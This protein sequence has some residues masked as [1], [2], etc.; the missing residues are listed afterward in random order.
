L[1]E[2]DLLVALLRADRSAEIGSLLEQVFDQY[3]ARVSLVPVGGRD[4]NRGQIE[5]GTDPGKGI[6][7]RI[8]NGIDGVLELEEKRHNGIPECKSPREAAMSWLNVPSKGLH[9]LSAARRRE[10]A[11]SVVVTVTEGDDKSHRTVTIVDS[12]IGMAAEEMP[13]TILSLGESN[14]VQKLYLSGAFG[15]GGSSTFAYCGYSVICSRSHSN[16]KN[17]GFTIIYYQDLPAEKYKHGN[18]VYLTLD[19]KLFEAEVSLEHFPKGTMVKHLGYDVTEYKYG[20]GPQSVYG[21][22]QRALFDP[23]IPVSLEDRVSKINRV[24]KGS[25]NALNGAVDDPAE[26]GPSIRYNVPMYHVSLGDFGHIGLE[27]WLL[28]EGESEKYEP[29]RAYVDN[30]K[31]ILL[32]VNGQTHAEYSGVL[33]RSK[34]QADL[35]YLR[36]RLIIHV[37]CNNLTPSAKRN[38]FSSSREDVRKGQINNLIEQEIVKALKSDDQLHILN[39]EAKSLTL[40]K[41]DT[42]SEQTI[43][44]EVAKVLRFHGFSATIAAGGG[45]DEGS[46]NT[47]SRIPPIP[48]APTH[49]FTKKIDI[50]DPPT[51]VKILAES[52]TDFYP[53]QRRYIRVETDAPSSYHNAEDSTKSR[54]N[55][56]INRTEIVKAGTTPLREG[57]MR[58]ILDCKS[59]AGVGSTGEL[60]I[61]LTVPGMPTLTDK[62]SYMI[63]KKPPP[64]AD[65]KHISIPKIR[66]VKVEGPEDEVWARLTW[67]DE[68]TKVASSSELGDELVVY[69]STLFPSFLEAFNHF[70][71]TNPTLASSFVSRYKTWLAVHSLLLE[72]SKKEST[73]LEDFDAWEHE[74]RCRLA[75]M[76]SIIADKEI[77]IEAQMPL[78][79]VD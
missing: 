14:K 22:L 46:K 66:F 59:E 32:T 47:P 33:I 49:K 68:I 23:I 27:Y 43:K 58:L 29:S 20:F 2:N 31:P 11:S 12:G 63:V 45:K 37:D 77:R 65:K 3:G 79:E 73:N 30:K 24:I 38:L 51:Y 75:T 17:V 13:S 60:T 4:N 41:T 61:E 15:Q 28:E 21:L 64:A 74:E 62:I 76:A 72:H 8:T 69:Y 36:N 19:G 7:E 56:I 54:F 10:L 40:R 53:D 1:N 6:V 55:I 16:P 5:I 67:P 48:R 42:E 18:Y 71:K 26:R 9:E 78:R 50:H 35:G 57:R 39:D 34:N 25:R 70:Q 52:P 44:T